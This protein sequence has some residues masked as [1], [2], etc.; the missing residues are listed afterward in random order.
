MWTR[1][2]WLLKAGP[3]DYMLA[4]SVAS[5]SLPVIG[6]HLEPLGAA[7]A[8]GIWGY[9]H[10]PDFLGAT[11][12]FLVR[13]RQRRAATAGTRC[14]QRRHGSR[15]ARHRGCQGSG[16]RVA[17]ARKRPAAVE[18]PSA[19]S[20]RAP[21]LGALRQPSVPAAGRL[22]PQGPACRAGPR[23]DL[24]AGRRLGA[25]QPPAAGLRV[26]VA[27][28]RDGLGVPVHRLSGGATPPLARTHHRRQDRDRLGA[29]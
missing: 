4:M 14:H 1:A 5:A 26:D 24:R 11:A 23:A 19:P 8:M 6:K 29:R 22:A 12:T 7:T 13:A 10:M 25:R 16:D 15:T 2:R 3:S 28:G 18:V 9:R 17:C 20:Q 21:H 27:S